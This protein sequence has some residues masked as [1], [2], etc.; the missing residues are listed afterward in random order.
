M[1]KLKY[2]I[3]SN[4]IIDFIG[5]KLPE[6]KEGWIDSILDAEI[7]ISVINKL[8]VLVGVNLELEEIPLFEAFI[9]TVMVFPLNEAVENKTIDIRKTINLKLP[10]AI[11]AATALVHNLEMITRNVKD[12]SRVPGLRIIDPFGI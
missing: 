11:I 5:G 4:T 12:F 3:D 7:A 9:K 6:D 2:L 8:E 1:E 10:D